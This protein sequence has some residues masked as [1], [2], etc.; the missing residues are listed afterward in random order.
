MKALVEMKTLVINQKVMAAG[1]TDAL[2]RYAKKII[3][4]DKLKDPDITLIKG[5]IFNL[6]QQV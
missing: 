5:I 3:R 6:E 4:R 1:T 2:L